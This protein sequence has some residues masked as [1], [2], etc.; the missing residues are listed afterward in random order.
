M[1]DRRPPLDAP[2]GAFGASATVTP[3]GGVAVA[4]RVIVAEVSE[5]FRAS[6]ELTIR[7]HHRVIDLQRADVP[8]LRTGS[9]IVVHEGVDAGSYVVD[10]IAE[11][12][13]EVISVIARAA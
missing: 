6:T 1:G 11:E 10:A 3:A 5:Q 8:S 9:T 4:T 7:L 13:A 12:T 2:F